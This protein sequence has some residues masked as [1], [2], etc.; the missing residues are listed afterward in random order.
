MA[1]F[2]CGSALTC[3]TVSDA[4]SVRASI[5]ESLVHPKPVALLTIAL[6]LATV[7][8]AVPLRTFAD[9]GEAES[10]GIRAGALFG[11]LGHR[12][13]SFLQ[14]ACNSLSWSMLSQIPRRD[15]NPVPQ[16]GLRRSRALLAIGRSEM[17]LQNHK[18][19]MEIGA[20]AGWPGERARRF[21]P[22]RPI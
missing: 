3:T 6:L 14:G 5:E 13:L 17:I 16:P 8:C 11:A 10:A 7:L 2:P 19:P 1:T 12:W 4:P 22:V 18:R 21:G 9:E 20:W 15:P